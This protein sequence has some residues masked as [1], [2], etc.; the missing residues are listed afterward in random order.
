MPLYTFVMD[1]AGGTYVS[2]VK[3]TSP[4]S[5]VK[6]WASELPVDEID[7]FGSASKAR[8]IKDVDDEVPIMIAGLSNVWCSTARIRG[9]LALI[10]FVRTAGS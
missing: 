1:Y 4:K 9:K 8:L 10:N 7:K 3:A 6:R 2:Q 5:A